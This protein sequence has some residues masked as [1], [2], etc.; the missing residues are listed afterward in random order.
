MKIQK[1]F[2]G[3]SNFKWL[4]KELVKL[5]SDEKSYFSKKRIESGIAFVI[6]QCGMVLWMYSNLDCSSSDLAIW[7]GIETVI[8]G[9]ALNQIQKE[10][11][12]KKNV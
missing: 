4:V 6:L 7:S 1:T 8:C 10:K 9:Y 5:Y 11:I 2:I 12:S 3:Y